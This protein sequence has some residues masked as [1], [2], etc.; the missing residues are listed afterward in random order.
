MAEKSK[1]QYVS[2]GLDLVAAGKIHEAIELYQKALELDPNFVEAI[3]ALAKAHELM[4][5]LDE[6]IRI[7]QE[8][9]EQHPTEPFLHTSLSQCYQKKGMIPEAEEEMA[10]AWRLQQNF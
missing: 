3:L 8:A 1:E 7:L 2:E 9:I 5:D 4:G 6:A 10:I